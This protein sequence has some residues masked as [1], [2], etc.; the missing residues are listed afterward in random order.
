MNRR[1]VG[2]GGRGGCVGG[3]GAEGDAGNP[4]EVG[5]DEVEACT[6]VNL[7]SEVDRGEDGKPFNAKC[8]LFLLREEGTGSYGNYSAVPSASVAASCEREGMQERRQLD[9]VLQLHGTR[10]AQRA[11]AAHNM[12]RA[13]MCCLYLHEAQESIEALFSRIWG[14]THTL[15]FASHLGQL[16]VQSPIRLIQFHA[17]KPASYEHG[18][19]KDDQL[20]GDRFGIMCFKGYWATLSFKWA[21]SLLRGVVKPLIFFCKHLWHCVFSA[22]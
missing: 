4:G 6:V 11:R 22:G 9:L 15:S 21:P 7:P 17:Q 14:M 3:G 10:C 13:A 18:R 5:G 20:S 8:D 2:G 12:A 19:W 1:G 16:L